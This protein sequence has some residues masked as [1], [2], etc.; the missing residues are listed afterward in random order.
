[1]SSLPTS[2]T[3]RDY[4]SN[5]EWLLTI[6]SQECPEI[7][8]YNYSGPSQSLTR[9]I[10]HAMDNLEF[11][12][13]QAFSES[14]IATA[15][16]KQSLI[17]IART[18]DLLPTLPV[19]ASTIIRITRKSPLVGN[20]KDSN[21]VP[22]AVIFIPQYTQ[23]SAADG[24]I[25]TLMSP[26]NLSEFDLYQDVPARQGV[27]NSLTLYPNNFIV[28]PNTGRYQYN[29]GQNISYDT[30]SVV[31][32][33][34][35][36]WTLVDSF[37]RSFSDDAQYYLDIYADLYN[38]VADTIWLTLGNG[39]QGKA[40]S[41]G[42]Y[43]TVNYIQCD[44][45]A[46]NVASGFITQIDGFYPNYVSVT[47]II[48]SNGG[49]GVE[50]I[51][52]YRARIP[53]VVRTQRRAVTNEDYEAV[54]LSIPGVASTQVVDRND[55]NTQYP[56]EYVIIYATPEGG[57][58]LPSNLYNAIM[59]ECTNKGTLGNWP[60]R[61]LVY[62]AIETPVD[63]FLSVGVATGFY[64]ATVISSVTA[65]INSFFLVDN[66]G[67]YAPFLVSDLFK[68]IMA[69]PG[70]SWLDFINLVDIQPAI[71]YRLVAGSIVISQAV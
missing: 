33:S 56:W 57:G 66:M 4:T 23:C 52:K 40:P 59:S 38:G 32:N 26:V 37:W 69:V 44:G 61:Y 60:G 30:I 46:G 28:D 36:P 67:I 55:D 14:F 17:D 45:E 63:I 54:V 18:V 64:P 29:L 39:V 12:I 9:L 15:Q 62:S 48:L 8:N 71:G 27:W 10:A 5:L 1:M 3:A 43:Y 35:T 13:D 68:I 2:F 20:V 53:M 42:S 22:T 11:Y 16:F 58:L 65:A 51:E 49:S 21:G 31:E 19:A 41:Q 70:V 7:T 47:N 25:F 34:L 24:T 50:S 6:L